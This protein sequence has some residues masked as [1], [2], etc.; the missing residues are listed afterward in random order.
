[1]RLIVNSSKLDTYDGKIRFYLPYT[2]EIHEFH[3]INCSIPYSFYNINEYNNQIQV[4]NM[5]LSLP[6]KQY[7]AIQLRNTLQSLL[8]NTVTVTFDRQSLKYSFSSNNTFSIK[9]L[10]LN[11]ILGMQNET[12]YTST[13]NEVTGK[14][15]I[16]GDSACDMTNRIHNIYI[17]SN[18]APPN[19]FEN[20]IEGN[21]ILY[22]IPIL[23]NFGGIIYY[24]NN[25]NNLNAEINQSLSL[26]EIYVTDTYNNIIN[27][28]GLSY[29][30]EFYMR[31]SDDEEI[32]KNFNRYIM[33]GPQLTN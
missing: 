27:M 12:E 23:T 32:M 28:N 33:G 1:M 6:I 2:L 13:L 15:F 25:T 19:I 8:P 22:R 16:I 11:F 9:P 17:K 14:Y 10:N 30:L 3:L 5:I 18:I 31:T 4:N 24:Q 21:N 20:E 7:N 29:Q 26:I